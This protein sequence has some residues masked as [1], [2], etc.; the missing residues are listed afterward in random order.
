MFGQYV[1]FTTHEGQRD[2]LVTELLHA[3][4]AMQAV[5]G[6]LLYLVNMAPSEPDVIWVTEVWTDPAAH[7]AS[8]S[9]EVSQ[10]LIGQARK[11]IA[12]VEAIALEPVGGKGIVDA[13]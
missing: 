13:G 7:Q 11:Y 6:C 5:E 12:N 10:T 4:E 8:L 9:L 3:A 1:K 2:L